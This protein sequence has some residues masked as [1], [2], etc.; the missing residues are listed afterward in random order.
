MTISEVNKMAKNKMKTAKEG[1][2]PCCGSEDIEY[3]AFEVDMP[4]GIYY[5]CT[6]NECGATFDEWYNVSFEGQWNIY[7]DKVGEAC[8]H[9][10]GDT[11]DKV[12]DIIEQIGETGHY[13]GEL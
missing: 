13:E 9:L 1:T 12:T 5:P 10:E 3:G 11:V 6:C 2:C 7:A 8:K 4:T